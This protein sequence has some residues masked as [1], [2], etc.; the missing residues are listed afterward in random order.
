MH[1]STISFRDRSSCLL[2]KLFCLL[3]PLAIQQAGASPLS[4]N[5]GKSTPRLAII[6]PTAFQNLAVLTLR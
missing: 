5:K 2:F 6:S 4:V 1:L 3:C